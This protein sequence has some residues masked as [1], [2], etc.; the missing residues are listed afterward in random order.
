MGN[1]VRSYWARCFPTSLPISNIAFSIVVFVLVVVFAKHVLKWNPIFLVIVPIPNW[2]PLGFL[3]LT[4]APQG[5]P[6]VN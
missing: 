3:E 4:Q 6:L 2:K 1:H 5:H